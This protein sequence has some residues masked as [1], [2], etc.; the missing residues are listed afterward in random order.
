MTLLVV[1]AAATWAL[2]GVIWY[3]QLVRYPRFAAVPREEFPAYQEGNIR[4]MTYAVGPIMICEGAAAAALAWR[5]RDGPALAGLALL[6]VLWSSTAFVQLPLHRAL[7]G[8]F[9]DSLHRRLL[10][11]NWVRT[12][13]WSARGV[14]TL[15]MLR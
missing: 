3:V 4:R 12:A 15:W 7:Q 1:H 13:A 9:D 2:V 10:R 14:L 11:T 8:G 6:A 5:L